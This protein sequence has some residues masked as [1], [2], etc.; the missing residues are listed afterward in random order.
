MACMALFA[1]LC[2]GFAG[3]HP[4]TALFRHYFY[5]RIQK[6]GAI[7]GCI[8]GIPRTQEKGTY[9]EGAQKERW[10]EWRSRWCWIEEEDPQ[11]FFQVRKAPTVRRDDWGDVDAQDGKLTIAI[12]RIH[13]SRLLGSPWR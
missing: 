1:H 13:C 3:V 10:E 12:T 2:E 4:S 8:A 5:P 6:G 11:E 7:S 9:P